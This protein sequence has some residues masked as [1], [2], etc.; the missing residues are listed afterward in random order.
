[1]LMAELRLYSKSGVQMDWTCP[2]KRFW[3]YEYQGRGIGTGNTHLELFLGQVLHDGL[4]A[5]AHMHQAGV[6]DIDLI[7]TTAKEQMITSLMGGGTGMQE[8]FDFANEQAALV[9][10]LLRG[11]Y[12]Q[13]WPILMKQY[14]VIKVV[15]QKMLFKHDGLGFMAIPD[16][17]V[18]DAEGNNWYV[19]YKSTS[20]KKEG[21]INS[22]NTAIQLHSTIK[23]IESQIGE[24]VTGVIVQGLYKGFESYGKQSSPF[25]YAYRRNGNP[26]FSETE[27]IYEYRPGFK[28]VPTWELEGGVKAWV[29][30]MPDHVLAEQFPQTPPIFVK[31]DMINS[32]FEQRK[33]REKEIELAVTMMSQS[34]EE[35]QK[36][37][38]DVA[39]PQRFDQ[40][41]PFFGKSCAYKKLCHGPQGVDPLTNGFEWR[42][43]EHLE[44]F[45]KLAGIGDGDC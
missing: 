16:L 28:R 19:E 11:F 8:E 17:V 38:R 33:W 24:A 5:I 32:F 43:E 45:K 37:L 26:P 9:E 39:F 34:D 20:S 2:R 1:M 41:D 10:G 3:A 35:S 21:W 25:C 4:S 22:W 27:T 31:D 7:A 14:P 29:E 23:A 15:E 13:V 36:G 6:V 12:K 30:S 44:E 18:A 42:D 40:C